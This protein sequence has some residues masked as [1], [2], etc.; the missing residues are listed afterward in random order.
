MFTLLPVES[1]DEHGRQVK[2]KMVKLLQLFVEIMRPPGFKCHLCDHTFLPFI[3]LD[4]HKEMR[5]MFLSM[6]KTHLAT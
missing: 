1:V 3:T 6:W 5:H 2:L 4:M